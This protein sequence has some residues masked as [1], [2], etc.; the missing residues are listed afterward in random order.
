MA[1]ATLGAMIH[2]TLVF[3]LTRRPARA[4]SKLALALFL[5][6]LSTGCGRDG[7]DSAADSS[8]Y[9]VL[10]SSNRFDWA[11]AIARDGVVKFLLF[12]ELAAPDASGELEGRLAERW[13]PLPD[14]RSWTIH[15]RPG[16][17][18][19]DGVPVTAHD[20]K[21]TVDL[22]NH[23]DVLYAEN[24]IESVEVLDD[25]TF[26]MTYKP[27]NAWHTYWYPG[28]WTVFYP[29]HLL[30]HLDPA[31]FDQWEFWERPVGNG[32]FR[33]VR[34][35]PQT[36]VEFEANPEFYS[37]EPKIDRVIVKFGPESITDLLAGNVDAMNLE[38]RV[39]LRGVRE[40]DRFQVHYEAW[41]DISAM[42]S[43]IY[44][45]DM[46]QFDDARVRRAIAHAIDRKE[47]NRIL[48]KWPDLPLIDVPFTEDQYWNR[49]LP[50]PLAYDPALSRRL[51]DE[52]GWRDTDGDD[53]RE[54]GGVQF[55]FTIIHELRYQP[56]AVFVQHKLAEVGIQA[57]LTTL[58]YGLLWER[59]W[60]GDFDVA[61]NYIWASPGD[62]DAGLVMVLGED[63]F[64][65]YDNP[66]VA[67]LANAALDER[68]PVALRGIYHELAPIIQSE[69]PF[70]VLTFGTEA[71]VANTRVKGLSSPFRAN[72][73]W[74][75]GHLW[76]EGER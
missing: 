2:T 57:E 70:T 62:P 45:H 24:P 15:L 63:S 35:T 40:D 18:W 19:H 71:Y 67:K 7:H 38:N 9:T 46:P 26:T 72:P 8:T 69:Q 13:E 59:T 52:V 10:Y 73:I 66:R 25:S 44:N 12:L 4:G 37:G 56:A 33:F 16:V 28:Y 60:A 76:L 58:D 6:T 50:E 48:L 36:M 23:P 42:V 68:D 1:R 47:L 75:T 61:L 64:M 54:R 55:N 74:Y 51:L 49:E 11:P 29:K 65:G 53:V 39:A 22:W 30:G 27:G 5:L 20:V 21:F 43:L 3:D 17:K 14:H 41:D 32:P 34:H 31:E